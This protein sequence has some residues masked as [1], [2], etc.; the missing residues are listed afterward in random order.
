MI[1]TLTKHIAKN[2]M[3]LKE[4]NSCL[5]FVSL[6]WRDRATII[7]FN[8]LNNTIMTSFTDLQYQDS[9]IEII[10]ELIT[11]FLK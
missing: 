10:E 4:R 11:D 6:V 3:V 2:T 9:D 1:N 5:S 7:M 8:N